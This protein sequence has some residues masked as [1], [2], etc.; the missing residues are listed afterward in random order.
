M[1]ITASM[2]NA[3]VLAD[4][5]GLE[6]RRV[7]RRLD[8]ASIRSVHTFYEED[9]RLSLVFKGRGLRAVAVDAAT[10]ADGATRDGIA[11]LV[12][13]LRARGARVADGVDQLLGAPAPTR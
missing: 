2:P 11:R 12:A 8:A 5:R 6:Q 9:G 10:L 7:A 4:E 1:L 3:L 13:T